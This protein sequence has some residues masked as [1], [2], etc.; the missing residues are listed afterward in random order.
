MLRNWKFCTKSCIQEK[1]KC[2]NYYACVTP[3]WSARISPFLSK[4]RTLA[5]KRQAP[6]AKIGTSGTLCEKNQNLKHFNSH[7]GGLPDG[8]TNY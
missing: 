3:S 4:D 7:L 1:E 5:S 8:G 2:D 6:P